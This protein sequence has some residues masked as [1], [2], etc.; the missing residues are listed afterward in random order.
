MV[1][2]KQI[3]SRQKIG[4]IPMHMQNPNDIDVSTV[5]EIEN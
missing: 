5:F 4:N 1:I 3:I 2:L